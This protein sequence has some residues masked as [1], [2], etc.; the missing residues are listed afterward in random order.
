MLSFFSLFALE[1]TKVLPSKYYRCPGD[2]S[3]VEM[4][5]S[6]DK[7]EIL[8]LS[9]KFKVEFVQVSNRLDQKLIIKCSPKVASCIYLGQQKNVLKI[10]V[11]DRH[12]DAKIEIIIK[13]R[14]LRAL[15]TERAVEFVCK[16]LVQAHSFNLTS[17]GICSTVLEGVQVP[18]LIVQIKAASHLEMRGQAVHT[19]IEQTSTNIIKAQDFNSEHLN[20]KMQGNGCVLAACDTTF[21]A[22]LRGTGRVRIYGQ[23]PVKKINQ[24]GL[25]R[26]TYQ[27]SEG[28]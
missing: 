14:N 11:G 8:E 21:N 24:L 13:S 5:T 10:K 22:N 6:L 3:R 27:V 12:L 17:S 2:L 28:G 20:I 1:P 23:P 16:R 9:G 7:V 19:Y 4:H 18:K 15:R 25:V 26:L